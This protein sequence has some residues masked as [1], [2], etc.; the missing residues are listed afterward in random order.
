MFQLRPLLTLRERD[1]FR[2]PPQLYSVAAWVAGESQDFFTFLLQHDPEV[3]LQ[4]DMGSRSQA[5]REELTRILLDKTLRNEIFDSRNVRRYYAGLCYDGI[6]D[7]L[8]TYL[9][10]SNIN[11]NVRWLALEISEDCRVTDLVRDLVAMIKDHHLVNY[12]REKA[13]GTLCAVLPDDRLDELVQLL[14]AG[15]EPDDNDTILAHFLFRLIPQ[16]LSVAQAVPYIHEPK[17]YDLIG[18]YYMFLRNG[19]IERLKPDDLPSVLKWLESKPDGGNDSYPFGNLMDEVL[20]LSLRHFDR[21]EIRAAMINFLCIRLSNESLML[22]DKH[23]KTKT[24]LSEKTTERRRWLRALLS[25]GRVNPDHVYRSWLHGWFYGDQGDFEWVLQEFTISMLR[26]QGVW[27]KAAWMLYNPARACPCWDYF[28]ELLQSSEM[29]RNMFAG[30]RTW[31]LDEPMALESQARWKNHQE[32]LESV[33]KDNGSSLVSLEEWIESDLNAAEKGDFAK[34]KSLCRH[35]SLDKGKQRE[36]WTF[37]EIT[38]WPGWIRSTPQRQERIKKAA[39][40]FLIHEKYPPR[41]DNLIEYDMVAGVAAIWPWRDALRDDP[42]LLVAV[43]ENW[44]DA[45][46]DRQL[47]AEEE[48]DKFVEFA[49]QLSPTKTSHSVWQ[50]VLREDKKHGQI[51]CRQKIETVWNEEISAMAYN[52]VSKLKL[53][54]PSVIYFLKLMARHQAEKART[55]ISEILLNPLIYNFEYN[56]Y[57]IALLAYLLRSN[58]AVSWNF[59]WPLINQSNDLAKGVFSRLTG[60]SL[61]S[62]ADWLALLSSE[63]LRDLYI[64]LT[65]LYPPEEDIIH[66]SGPTTTE[67]LVREMRNSVI[68][69]LAEEL[70]GS[71]AKEL[72]H[73]ATVFPQQASWLLRNYHDACRRQHQRNWHP[74]LLS[75]LRCLFSSENSNWINDGRDLSEAIL[76]V[77]ERLSNNPLRFWNWTGGEQNRKDFKPKDE[78]FISAEIKGELEK[79][80][81]SQGDVANREVQV[82]KLGRLDLLVQAFHSTGNS[83]TSSI[84]SV[85]VEVKRS[86][87]RRVRADLR[88]QLVRKY[89]RDEGYQFGVYVVAWFKSPKWLKP[90]N[91]LNSNSVNDAQIE[92]AT[93]ASEFDE[94]NA[95]KVIRTAILDCTCS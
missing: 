66:Y 84:I 30:L 1:A 40:A 81:S 38:E 4:A 55:L 14:E 88:D 22:M 41:K 15:I 59:V 51:F 56:E 54:A 95:P 61:G 13:C 58:G 75:H 73:L 8:R 48:S 64:L 90:I 80:L 44:L 91:Y 29:L 57:L 25:G 5:H 68:K 32:W 50:L 93:L 7:L 60:D 39:R 92:L 33:Q 87:N 34:W 24:F 63:N 94:K 11:D 3:L 62:R 2:V 35:L 19:L 21:V 20:Y 71:G 46:I 67:M 12:L 16:K 69:T 26:N 65:T 82:K 89:L 18:S 86:S 45:L 37:S 17:N 43:T 70:H 79:S 9:I 74:A 85:V 47:G 36:P 27:A 49:Y 52:A 23:N 83:D 53:N 76:E 72:L 28:W 31:R 77:I 78:G 6:A 10:N 42:T